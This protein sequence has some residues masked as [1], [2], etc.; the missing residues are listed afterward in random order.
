[1]V[2]AVK[3]R[4]FAFRDSTLPP[5]C[6]TLF[7]TAKLVS[8]GKTLC[9]PFLYIKSTFIL[10]NSRLRDR[11]NNFFLNL[12]WCNILCPIIIFLC[13]NGNPCSILLQVSHFKQDNT[14]SEM[15]STFRAFLESCCWPDPWNSLCVAAFSSTWTRQQYPRSPLFLTQFL[16][17]TIVLL[18]V[19]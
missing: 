12:Y 4:E 19:A 7:L 3:S 5:G 1:M 17:V 14:F 2:G 9:Y 8:T 18:H 6:R 10:I 13:L 15:T 16:S 11:L